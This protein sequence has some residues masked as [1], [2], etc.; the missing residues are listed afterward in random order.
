MKRALNP[1]ETARP[2]VDSG[3]MRQSFSALLMI[4]EES[5]GKLEMGTRRVLL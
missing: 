1:P 4:G 2:P 5:A 3:K